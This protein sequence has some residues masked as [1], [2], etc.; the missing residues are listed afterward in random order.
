MVIDWLRYLPSQSQSRP[1][2][3]HPEDTALDNE[4][5][6]SSPCSSYDPDSWETVTTWGHARRRTHSGRWAQHAL[7]DP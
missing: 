7:K 6:G 3:R 2:I 5:M 1:C 4:G